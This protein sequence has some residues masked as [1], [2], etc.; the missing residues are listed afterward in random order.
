MDAERP[1]ENA[2]YMLEKAADGGF[3]VW[4]SEPQ[5]FDRRAMFACSNV[6]EAYAYMNGHFAAPS[7]V[8]ERVR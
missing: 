1:N 3:I 5:F 4:K 2:R 6:Q 8:T 7:K